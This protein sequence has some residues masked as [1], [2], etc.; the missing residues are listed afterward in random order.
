[1]KLSK[2]E[3][4]EIAEFRKKIEDAK[5]NDIIRLLEDLGCDTANPEKLKKQIEAGKLAAPELFED[6][7]DTDND[8]SNEQN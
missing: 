8:N 3:L 4:K 5:K 7:S 6:K 2:K 1:M